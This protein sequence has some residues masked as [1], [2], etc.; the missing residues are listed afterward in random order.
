MANSKFLYSLGFTYPA[1]SGKIL[2]LAIIEVADLAPVGSSS[3]SCTVS[4]RRLGVLFKKNVFDILYCIFLLLLSMLLCDLL[5][6][7]SFL[8]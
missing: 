1:A 7:F 6:F 2:A 8:N 5:D 4:L 3:D